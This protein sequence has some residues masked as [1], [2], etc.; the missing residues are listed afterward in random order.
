[1]QR[2]CPDPAKQCNRALKGPQ[3]RV[4]PL[5]VLEPTYAERARSVLAEATTASL[6][7]LDPDGRPVVAPV[8]I[9][10][11]GQGAPVMVL[12]N[13]ST[14]TIRGRQDVRA[15]ISIGDRLLIQGDLVA[16]PGMQQLELQGRFLMRHPDLAPVVESLDF[17]WLRVVPT[18]VRWIDDDGIDQWLR[19]E[20]L[21]GAD[22]DPLAAHDSEIVAEVAKTLGEDLLLMTRALGGRWLAS[23]A[24]LVRIDRYGLVVLA[25]EPG[26][27][28]ESRIPFP[29]R[30]DEI[31][32]VHA[33]LGAL[34]RAARSAPTDEQPNGAGLMPKRIDEFGAI[35]AGPSRRGEVF[36]SELLQPDPSMVELP[37][38]LTPP[39][40]PS[41]L[42]DPVESDGSG[43]TDVDAVDGS[44]HG[45]GDPDVGAPRGMSLFDA[46]EYAGAQTR[47]LGPQQ[48]RDA[49]VSIE[50]ELRQGKSISGGSE[51]D[52][53][54]P[55]PAND[56][57]PVGQG[58]EPGVGEGIGLAHADSATSSVEG[59]ATGGVDEESVDTET[60]STAEDDAEV[61]RVVG[62]LA[63]DNRAGALENL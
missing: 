1:M 6:A 51:S 53:P 30:L 39:S 24:E 36:H 2:C 43:R 15:G 38:H 34:M 27:T 12:S 47:A 18:R 7:T 19:A 23:E 28:R 4:D 55:L 14:H 26:E 58:V 40:T 10:D 50:D 37:A 45:N 60:S 41:G 29:V 57:E 59:I 46:L 13:L 52:E 8:P 62:V 48:D 63:D 54:E 33:A 16:V 49:F 21:A 32:E 20:D 22:P 17:S 5:S 42:L 61:G 3:L 31:D 56:V 44:G 9:V 11:D 25:T 35:E